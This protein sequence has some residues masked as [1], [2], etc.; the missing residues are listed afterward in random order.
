MGM[1]YIAIGQTLCQRL[2]LSPSEV[3]DPETLLP[4]RAGCS[5]LA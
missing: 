2:K 5:K 4:R 1:S 3:R